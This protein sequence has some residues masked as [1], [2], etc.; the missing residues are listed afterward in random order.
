M[1]S[2][3]EWKRYGDKVTNVSMRC[4]LCEAQVSFVLLMKEVLL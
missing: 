1:I 3:D 2:P 4:L